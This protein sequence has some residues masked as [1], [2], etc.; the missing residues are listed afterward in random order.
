MYVLPCDCPYEE[1]WE[2]PPDA[3]N[4]VF[5]T[6]HGWSSPG[7]RNETRYYTV[8]CLCVVIPR[9]KTKSLYILLLTAAVCPPTWPWHTGFYAGY[10]SSA[11]MFGRLVGS[12]FWGYV[13]DRYGRLPVLYVGL[14]SIAI[15][16]VAFGLSTVF[17]WA[18]AFR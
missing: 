18:V 13:A 6:Y 9:R 17:V 15:F 16:S 3:S 14:C 5:S 4:V 11:F 8:D 12:Y 1:R 10:L 7:P 2:K